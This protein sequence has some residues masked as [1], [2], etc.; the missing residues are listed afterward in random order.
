MIG[1]CI[2]KNKNFLVHR[3]VALRL[4]QEVEGK[5]QVNHVDEN[6]ENNRVSN[7]ECCTAFENLTHNDRHLRVA[8]TK[9]A[10]GTYN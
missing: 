10:N 7:L 4:L 1:V 8:E 3:I 9:I 2:D 6:K 5:D